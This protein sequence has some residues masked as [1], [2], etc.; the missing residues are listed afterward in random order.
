[1]SGRVTSRP[2]ALEADSSIGIGVA[3]MTCGS[4]TAWCSTVRRAGH[5]ENPGTRDD[6]EAKFRGLAGVVFPEEK[7]TRLVTT[8]RRLPDL[9][10]VAELATLAS[11]T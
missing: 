1:V 10:D 9:P 8:L 7:V 6:V 2:E 11:G 5:A 4:R 3:E